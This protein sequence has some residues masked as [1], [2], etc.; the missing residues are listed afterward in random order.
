MSI[1]L[2]FGMAILTPESSVFV[3]LVSL[4]GSKISFDL[5]VIFSSNIK[6]ACYSTT[7]TRIYTVTGAQLENGTNVQV[8]MHIGVGFS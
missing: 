5:I 1:V 6:Q 2:Q 7:C 3:Y 4:P 8:P